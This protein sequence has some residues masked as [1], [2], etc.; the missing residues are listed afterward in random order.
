[1]QVVWTDPA[2]ARVREIAEHIALDDPDAAERWAVGLFDAVERLASFPESR[3][4]VP[5]LGARTARELIHG[6]YRVF[7][8]LGS[9][10]GILSVRHGGQLVRVEELDED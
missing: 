1:M 7:Y 8:R 6:G 10:V 2:L 5:E 3:R 4:V 9:A